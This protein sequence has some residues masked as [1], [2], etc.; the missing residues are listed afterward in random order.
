[1][2]I[3]RPFQGRD[4]GSIPVTRSKSDNHGL[5]RGYRLLNMEKLIDLHVHT[6]ASDGFYSPSQIVKKA[7]DL[8]LSAIAITD[9]DTI[10][11]V[12]P[13]LSAGKKLGLEVVPGVEITTRWKKQN[14]REFHIL[15]YYINLADKK[16]NSLLKYCQK[17]R[18][19]R[20]RKMIK[21]LQDLGFKINLTQVQNLAQRA[22]GRPHLARA[23]IE[24][25]QKKLIQ[26][27]GHLPDLDEFFESYL[28]SG[29]PTYVRKTVPE[30]EQVIRL[31]HQSQGLAILAHPGCDLEI[32]E[33]E[34][35]RQ[36]VSWGLD[37][38]EAICAKE[39][40]KESLKYIQYFSTLA[41]KYKLLITGGSDFHNDQTKPGL[42]LLNWKMKI[43]YQLLKE[44]KK[45]L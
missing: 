17:Q 7:K 1:M 24:N 44:L 12:R 34:I 16:L 27:F 9:H 3:T 25:N 4:T 8:G 32:G 19:Q 18:L 37:G 42:G 20:A 38:L 35:I 11:G 22:I 43:P 45:A 30:P 14:N 39:T 21:K 13:S 31:I 36:G 28:R 10:D 2:A 33:E 15:G 23:A 26:I 6:T 40:K 5:S 41:R 29:Q